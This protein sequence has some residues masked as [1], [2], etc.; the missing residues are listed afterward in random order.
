MERKQHAVA[1]E[2]YTAALAASVVD[3]EAM[4]PPA[5]V[6]VLHCNRAA[7][8]QAL[9]QMAEA[10]AD[11]GRARA[12]NPAYAKVGFRTKSRPSEPWLCAAI[13][14][15]SAIPYPPSISVALLS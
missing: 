12:L 5:V 4:V 6:A 10:L 14:S 3:G 2:H 15:R 11:C 7:A 9:D 1:M 13:S 8:Y